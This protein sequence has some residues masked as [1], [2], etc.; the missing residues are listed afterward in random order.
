MKRE[1]E[2]KRLM[3][4]I[5]LIH[6]REK[7]KTHSSEGKLSFKTHK[8]KENVF[9]KYEIERENLILANNLIKNSCDVSKYKKKI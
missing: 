2:N 7:L 6:S 3:K 5:S 4:S 8:T 9:K 1:E